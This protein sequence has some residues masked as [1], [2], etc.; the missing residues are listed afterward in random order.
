ADNTTIA[1]LAQASRAAANK[2][3][4]EVRLADDATSGTGLLRIYTDAGKTN[5]TVYQLVSGTLQASPL[6]GGVVGT[7]EPLVG[8]D[9]VITVTGFPIVRAENAVPK[10]VSVSVH[11]TLTSGGQTYE[12]TFAAA[13]RK[14]Q[15]Y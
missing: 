12:S 3:L 6:A 9:G 4:G 5:G 2:I 15:T 8:G 10:T 11:L 7:A 1:D 14:N 13:V